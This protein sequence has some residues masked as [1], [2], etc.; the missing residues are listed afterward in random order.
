MSTQFFSIRSC[1]LGREHDDA[2]AEGP[3]VPEQE[4]EQTE[5]RTDEL[6][7]TDLMTFDSFMSGCPLAL[8]R[9]NDQRF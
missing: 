3:I 5:N 1:S 2:S 9:N 6:K 4:V 8:N 7:L